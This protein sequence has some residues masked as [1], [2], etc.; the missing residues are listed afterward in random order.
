M[1]MQIQLRCNDYKTRFCVV[2]KSNA[3]RNALE[4]IHNAWQSFQCKILLKRLTLTRNKHHYCLETW[5]AD[6]INK[7][8]WKLLNPLTHAYLRKYIQLLNWNTDNCKLNVH[9]RF[10]ELG[11]KELFLARADY[12][13]FTYGHRVKRC[14]SPFRQKNSRKHTET[15]LQH[16]HSKRSSVCLYQ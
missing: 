3:E 8:R 2:N 7:C 5:T 13:S 9:Y 15:N 11:S 4:N 6:E 10:K 14:F 16:T 1:T 12:I